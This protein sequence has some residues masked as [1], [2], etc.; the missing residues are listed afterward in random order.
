MGKIV[1]PQRVK[2]FIGLIFP[3]TTLIPDIK[4]KLRS[5]FGNIDFESKILDFNYTGYYE[6]EFGVNL[7]RS[8]LSFSKLILPDKIAAIKNTTNK[9]EM[10]LTKGQ[11]RLINLDPGYLNDAKV[12]LATTKDYAHRI[13]L[14]DGIY[15][16]NTLVFTQGSFKPYP[17]TYPDY[18]TE[19][20]AEIFNQIRNIYMKQRK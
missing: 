9:L 19:Q 18:Q 4:K 2:L 17:W 7:K 1:K 8:F 3:E 13:Y 5:K 14:K 11:K 6:K 10:G 15:A 20:Y 16:E 12:V